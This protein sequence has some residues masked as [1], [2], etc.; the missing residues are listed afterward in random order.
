[1]SL[2]W[3]F[4]NTKQLVLSSSC[5]L[6]SQ[7]ICYTYRICLP[8]MNCMWHST[9]HSMIAVTALSTGCALLLKNWQHVLTLLVKSLQLKPNWRGQRYWC[10]LSVIGIVGI[11]RRVIQKERKS[12]KLTFLA[13]FRWRYGRLLIFCKS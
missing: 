5:W 2:K 6:L 8:R 11:S 3:W 10:T 12:D 9:R 7:R 4:E 13:P 1:M